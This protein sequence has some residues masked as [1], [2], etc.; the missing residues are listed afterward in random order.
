VKRQLNRRWETRERLVNLGQLLGVLT[1]TPLPQIWCPSWSNLIPITITKW[2]RQTGLIRRKPVFSQE[3]WI[4]NQRWPSCRR[5][6]EWNF[7]GQIA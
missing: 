5:K 3:N 4:S 6:Y 1:H 7:P 2:N